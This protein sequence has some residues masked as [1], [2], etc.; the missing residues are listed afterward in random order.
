MLRLTFN[1][2]VS[3]QLYE[4]KSFLRNPQCYK[5]KNPTAFKFLISYD[6]KIFMGNKLKL[7][8]KEVT[9]DL[10]IDYKRTDHIVEAFKTAFKELNG[11]EINKNY[12][13]KVEL[14]KE[15]KQY[16]VTAGRSS[17]NKQITTSAWFLSLTS[18]RYVAPANYNCDGK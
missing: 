16:F 3:R 17:K 9:K 1:P 11:Y 7:T 14:I 4:R 18:Y 15:N 5:I 6:K 13:L 10:Q 8:L 12:D 2:F